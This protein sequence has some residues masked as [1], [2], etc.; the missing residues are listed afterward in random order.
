VLQKY[1]IMLFMQK[2][3]NLFLEVP[4]YLPSPDILTLY[5]FT[6]LAL[7]RLCLETF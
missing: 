4:V 7:G 2:G 6:P 3:V 1:A 5:K